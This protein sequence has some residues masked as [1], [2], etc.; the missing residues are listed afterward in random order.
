MGDYF[1]MLARGYGAKSR[2][3]IR[4]DK[5][6]YLKLKQKFSPEPVI[7]KA[8]EA[9]VLAASTNRVQPIPYFPEDLAENLKIIPLRQTGIYKV[10]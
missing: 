2:I 9:Y 8:A 5:I 10:Y 6:Q 3:Y 7:S 4:Y 1:L